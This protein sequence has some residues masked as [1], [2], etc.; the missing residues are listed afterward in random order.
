MEVAAA[1]LGMMAVDALLLIGEIQCGAGFFPDEF[2]R[3]CSAYRS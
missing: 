2:R 1:V 3:G